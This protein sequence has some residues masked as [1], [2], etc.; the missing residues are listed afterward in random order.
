MNRSAIFRWILLFIFSAILIF[1]SLAISQ[2]TPM[3]LFNSA[4]SLSREG[5][6]KEAVDLLLQIV[7]EHPTFS[8]AD[9]SLYQAG[10]ISEVKV[11]DFNKAKEI[12]HRLIEDYPSS[13]WATRGQKRLTRLEN[14]TS[15]GDEALKIYNKAMADLPKTGAEK[16]LEIMLDLYVKHPDF[17]QRDQVAYWIGD[18]YSRLQNQKAAIRY[19][20]E[21][22]KLYPKS[23]WAFLGLEILGKAYLNVKEYDNAIVAFERMAPYGDRHPGAQMRSEQLVER[24]KADKA[25]QESGVTISPDQDASDDDRETTI[26]EMKTEKTPPDLADDASSKDCCGCN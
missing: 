24:A 21:L 26:K 22:Y 8:Q 19:L 14:A 2:K 18:T 4:M 15:S 17:G 3:E 25:K 10:I 11:E 13:S 1:P 20:E 16:T 12:Y 5:S 6:S 7:D 23:N 9:Q